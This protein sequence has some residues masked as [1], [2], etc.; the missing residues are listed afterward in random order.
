[1]KAASSPVKTCA[2]PSSLAPS[3]ATLPAPKGTAD[4]TNVALMLGTCAAAAP[5]AGAA[6]PTTL[7]TARC[8]A[9]SRA[10]RCTSAGSTPAASC[11]GRS[12]APA[13][14]PYWR[15]R[16]RAATSP[17]TC[18]ATCQLVSGRGLRHRVPPPPCMCSWEWGGVWRGFG[19]AHT[20]NRAGARRG[21]ACTLLNPLICL[22]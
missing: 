3:P 11:A 16:C 4:D 15:C 13:R 6:M 5:P 9:C 12:A 1:M 21:G 2:H 22:L 8:G 18:P 7:S 19:E 10:S 17:A 14:S 20:W